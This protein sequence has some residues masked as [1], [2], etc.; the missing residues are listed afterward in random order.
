MTVS[1]EV[2]RN[3]RVGDGVLDTFIFEFEIYVKT[4]IKVW[5]DGVPKYVDTHFTV[6]VAGIN[7][8]DGGTIVFTGGNI[9]INLAKIAIIL[10]LPLT[11]LTN[12][13][14]GDKFP[15]ETH[16][17]VADRL[18][19]IAQKIKGA[20]SRCLQL[21]TYSTGSGVLPTDFIANYFMKVNST[22]DGFEL[23]AGLPYSA[24]AGANGEIQFNDVGILGADADLSWNKVT[25]RL[26][27]KD[28]MVKGPWVDVRAH[29]AI[30]DSNGTTGNGTDDKVAIQNTFNF[31]TSGGILYI[32]RNKIFRVSDTLHYLGSGP[33]TIEG[34]GTL[35]FDT[36]TFAGY[37]GF[38]SGLVIEADLTNTSENMN[39]GTTL[40]RTGTIG[41]RLI[42]RDIKFLSNGSRTGTFSSAHHAL[43]L[44]CFDNIL[45]ENCHFEG[46]NGSGIAAGG[47][48]GLKIIGNTFKNI[49]YNG[50]EGPSLKTVLISHNHFIDTGAA[51]QI[52]PVYGE[53]CNNVM[54]GIGGATILGNPISAIHV[55]TSQYNES[56]RCS[57]HNNQ[58]DLNATYDGIE[59]TGIRIT[60]EGSYTTDSYVK[61][62]SIKNN[63]IKGGFSSG[64]QV[65]TPPSPTGSI[66]IS[67]NMIVR[68]STVG[69]QQAIKISYET[70]GYGGNEWTEVYNNEIIH[71]DGNDQQSI[72]VSG[73]G[74]TAA[75]RTKVI[76]NKITTMATLTAESASYQKAGGVI[77][78][79]WNQPGKAIVR[80][81]YKNGARIGKRQ[82]LG[83]TGA[84]VADGTTA[85]KAK[86]TNS[87]KISYDDFVVTKA[88]T[89]DLFDLTG[90]STT[91]VQYCKVLLCID[92]DGAGNIVVG[93]KVAAQIDARI[94]QIGID[95]DW[96]PVGVVEIGINY[97]G[98]DLAGFVFYDI[99]GEWDY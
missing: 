31:L 79:P 62:V 23:H 2:S 72:D 80:N 56:I 8:P 65:T 99:I 51:I 94:P 30:G 87:V 54:S 21:P 75:P 95:S 4:D 86:T 46:F 59:S 76:G 71:L 81:N 98:G 49:R 14:E 16:E 38:T 68:S 84:G 60:D 74:L 32:P 58:M 67:E 17:T 44:L 85:G 78:L 66:V 6:P 22:G 15:A 89:D 55:G 73:I 9:P 20:L 42:I 83:V 29:G 63:L 96:V 82:V 33:L 45:I 47:I 97:A 19:K 88:G 34:G 93:I 1:S 39:G 61:Y 13:V 26:Y 57:I 35:Y 5:V 48:E 53:I 36:T 64:I 70:D 25:K 10:D 40:N 28:L 92:S 52:G 90:V 7:N 3:D 91:G 69:T 12:Y 77:Y 24:P 43:Q 18:V 41:N 27:A 11:Q 50:I 37:D